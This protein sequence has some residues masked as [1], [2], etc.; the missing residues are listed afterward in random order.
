M[1][2]SYKAIKDGKT[3]TGVME[4]E[5]EDKALSYLKGNNL[6]ILSILQKL[7]LIHIWSI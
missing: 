7:S 6:T 1:E 3:I 4:A 2:Y 5:S